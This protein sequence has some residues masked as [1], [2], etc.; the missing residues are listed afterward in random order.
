MPSLSL[1]LTLLLLLLAVLLPAPAAGQRLPLH[2]GGV[3]MRLED[4]AALPRVDRLVPDGP[5]ARAGVRPGERVAAVGGRSVAGLGAAAVEDL[6]AGSVG[7]AVEVTLHAPEGA[8]TLRLV[9]EDVFAPTGGYTGTVAGTY[10]VVHHRPDGASRR[11]AE[12]I[13]A[14]AEQVAERG[15][16]GGAAEGRRFHLYLV[17]PDGASTSTRRARGDLL[18]WWAG[19]AY[20]GP[21]DDERSFGIPLAYLRFGEPGRRVAER[22][23]GRLG[24]GLPADELHRAAVREMLGADLAADASPA[25]LSRLTPGI[26]AAGASL[27]AYVRDRFGDRRLGELWRS[28][29]PFDS[30]VGR[31]LGVSER[32]LLADWSS[33]VYGLGPDPQAGPGTGSFAVGL[34]YGALALLF[35][36]RMAKRKEV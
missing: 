10:F 33:K 12:R 11:A 17:G 1:R 8:R 19:W 23:G 13:A 16:R 2:P 14:R 7:E 28:D 15:L 36:V 18:P 30:A 6:L 21:M 24:W 5:A 32:E 3:G 34:G 31:A 35:G 25:S 22:L 9:R 4:D 27:R 20:P 26:P 29:A